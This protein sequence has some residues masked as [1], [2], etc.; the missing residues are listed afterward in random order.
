MRVLVVWYPC[1]VL[2]PFCIRSE[3]G[4][5]RGKRFFSQECLHLT[6][7]CTEGPTTV[8]K[9]DG[10]KTPLEEKE[11]FPGKRRESTDWPRHGKRVFGLTPLLMRNS[12]SLAKTLLEKL[13]LLS[14]HSAI[15]TQAPFFPRKRALQ[16]WLNKRMWALQKH[17]LLRR[18]EKSTLL[19]PIPTSRNTSPNTLFPLSL[20]LVALPFLSPF[21]SDRPRPFLNGF[22][23]AHLNNIKTA[24]AQ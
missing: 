4:R 13:F 14:F 10:K 23:F 11:G 9:S 1:V 22:R 2:Y 7:P 5:K 15:R 12:C 3:K 17:T 16:S 19:F 20:L 24:C 6:F 18:E 21:S 8:R